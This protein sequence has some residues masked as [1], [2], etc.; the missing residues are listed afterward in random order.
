MAQQQ[1]ITKPYV[2]ELQDNDSLF[3]NHDGAL[4]QIKKS[5]ADFA[6]SADMRAEVAAREA[7][8]TS[9]SEKFTTYDSN[10][11][12]L[13]TEVDRLRGECNTL[14]AE[15][16]KQE[17][18]IDALMKLNKGQTYDILPEE[19]E[20]ASRT[21]PSGSKYVSVDRLGGKSVA[22][23]QLWDYGKTK[24]EAWVTFAYENHF[25]DVVKNTTANNGIYVSYKVKSNN[26][27]YVSY[28]AS[29]NDNIK[30]SL[31]L[32]I[33]LTAELTE[34]NKRY[35]D[36]ITTGNLTKPRNSIYLYSPSGVACSYRVGNIKVIDLTQ[37]F[38]A[39]NEPSTV[40][41]FEEM[42][43]D[44]YYEYCEPTIISSQ[45]D[46]VD[47][48]SADGTITQ[49]IT[50]GFPVLNSAGSVY[51]YIDLNE[52]KHR[53]R[54]GV[55][56]LGTID[57]EQGGYNNKTSW[58]PTSWRTNVK[59]VQYTNDKANILCN[60]YCTDTADNVEKQVND[61][62]ISVNR[63]SW[64]Y[65]YDSAYISVTPQ[66]FRTA[67]SGVMLYYE[68]AEEKITD[69]EIPTELTDWLPVEAGGTVT[70]RNADESKQLAVPNAVS[71]VRKLDEVN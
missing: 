48:A 13:Q 9:V 6:S 22:W 29:S 32:G 42:F 55:V 26:K 47:V 33:S 34:S 36:I 16:R 38:G 27:Y 1:I 59:P 24:K 57:W 68:F 69:I 49:Q 18:R 65:I 20:T 63:N 60:K 41:E 40:E 54:V 43:P 61:K 28:E 52:G 45:T 30:L 53:Q 4:R 64:V 5:G 31:S 23:N 46:R 10:A 35:R 56:D 21:A 17:N 37:M 70:F 71:W 66:E 19:G 11:A 51:D 15:N 14:A 8:E 2:E 7:F 12:A 58:V 39:G 62:T 3:I 50:T 67:M 44:D 25:Y